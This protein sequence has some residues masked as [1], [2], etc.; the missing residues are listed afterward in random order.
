[1]PHF[2]LNLKSA[3]F[4]TADSVNLILATSHDCRIDIGS[5]DTK[6]GAPGVT[7]MDIIILFLLVV[8]GGLMLLDAPRRYIIASW[9]LTAFL[10]VGLFK[11]HITS[12]LNLSF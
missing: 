1:M 9:L 5:T 6:S 3:R 2:N 10:I 7:V 11:H 8:T 12:A 4:H